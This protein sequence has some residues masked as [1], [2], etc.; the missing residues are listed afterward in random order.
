[1][2]VLAYRNGELAS[3]SRVIRH[4][5]HPGQC[6]VYQEKVKLSDCKR[7]YIAIT[8]QGASDELYTE[9]VNC[10]LTALSELKRK[11]VYLTIFGIKDLSAIIVGKDAAWAVDNG[12]LTVIEQDISVAM[13]S[14]EDYAKMALLAG[15]SVAEAIELAIAYDRLCGGQVRTYRAYNLLP[16]VEEPQSRE[17][18]AE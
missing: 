11:S 1:M 14:G 8:G 9:I 5:D 6:V 4:L 3:D 12:V 17:T 13:G 10:L 2:T 16:I 7:F 18:V 15:K